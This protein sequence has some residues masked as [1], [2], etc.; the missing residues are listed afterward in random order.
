MVNTDVLKIT[1]TYSYYFFI[2]IICFK[3]IKCVLYLQGGGK[4]ALSFYFVVVVRFCCVFFHLV[5]LIR[6]FV[7]FFRTG[8]GRSIQIAWGQKQNRRCQVP[9][10]TEVSE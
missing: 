10:W 1:C 3:F 6:M 9:L 5:R 4:K 7:V 8:T 2:G